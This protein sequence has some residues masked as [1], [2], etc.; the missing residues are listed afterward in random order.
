MA[1]SPP[2]PD[3]G[4][5]RAAEASG[6]APPL[7]GPV[8]GPGRAEEAPISPHTRREPI[9]SPAVC[10]YFGEKGALKFAHPP[11]PLGPPYGPSG[12]RSRAPTSPTGGGSSS[13]GPGT[14]R[15]PRPRDGPWIWGRASPR[16]RAPPG[17]TGGNSSPRG[18]RVRP[19]LP[20][21]RQAAPR[22]SRTPSSVVPSA[23]PL[24]FSAPSP[25]LVT[26][27]VPMCVRTWG[28][29][30]RPLRWQ[31]NPGGFPRARTWAHWRSRSCTSRLD[32]P[33]SGR[34]ASLLSCGDVEA[35]PGPPPTDWGEEDDALVPKLVADSCGRLG[36]SLV[37]DAFATPANHN[38]PAYWTRKDDAFAQPWDYATAGPL[39]ANPP[40][41][42]L[43]EVVAKAAQEGCLMLIIAPEWPGP[44]YP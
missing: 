16:P 21:A 27:A 31:A 39:W 24:P 12:P 41:S 20:S 36:I 13:H 35:N 38:F 5:G 3:Q 4:P 25:H 17:Q 10:E 26:L 33:T 34:G 9:A 37:R 2:G 30:G 44:Q 11:H 32:H 23:V 29:E 42:R 14:G 15:G 40:F 28:G 1:P 22:T 43:E 8:H 6:V 18:P 19:R 7:P